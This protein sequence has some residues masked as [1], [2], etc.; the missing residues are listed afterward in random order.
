MDDILASIRRIMLDEQARLQTGAPTVPVDD[1]ESAPVVMLDSSM[2]V[3]ELPP[4]A[5]LF[6][7][8]PGPVT[9]HDELSRPP[10]PL[11][12][13]PIL[14]AHAEPLDHSHTLLQ[15]TTESLP[16]EPA[17]D[18]VPS[19]PVEQV[20]WTHEKLTVTGGTATPPTVQDLVSV[21]TI[22]ALV[23]PAAA[24]AA[25]ASVEALLKELRQERADLVQQQSPTIEAVVRSEIRPLLKSW[26]DEHL[27]SLVERLVRGEI[28]RLV[29]GRSGR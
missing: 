2:I 9:M 4:A 10:E 11:P 5:E 6:R 14:V 13:A 8:G 16:P 25:A 17:S 24:A 12:E 18:D 27:P 1:E 7:I 20:V 29:G 22:E 15:V 28:E 21:Q 26:L 19:P 23:A 3:E